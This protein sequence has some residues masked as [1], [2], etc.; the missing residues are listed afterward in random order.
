[1]LYRVRKCKFSTLQLVQIPTEV[2]G[3]RYNLVTGGVFWKS[4]CY[5][6]L[7]YLESS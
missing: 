2:D 4:K 1:M 3:E 7:Y 5:I 6:L